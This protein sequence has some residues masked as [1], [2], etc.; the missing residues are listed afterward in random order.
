[1]E[2]VS[3]NKDKKSSKKKITKKTL[4]KGGKFFILL[5]IA[6]IALNIFVEVKK[7]KA[8]DKNTQALADIQTAIEKSGYKYDS[9]RGTVIKISNNNVAGGNGVV[10]S[11]TTISDVKISDV[12]TTAK[13]PPY[14]AIIKGSIIGEKELISF[15]EEASVKENIKSRKVTL[16]C[17]IGTKAFTYV[18]DL[19]S[20]LIRNNYTVTDVK[21]VET[22]DLKIKNGISIRAKNNQVYI[23]VGNLTK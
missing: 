5:V 18:Q 14:D 22:D 2:D 8:D 16:I 15:I 4:T 21:S 1:M 10:L 13:E 3:Q 19:S 9:S 12:T 7:H 6:L 17:V 23:Y 11:G 20:M